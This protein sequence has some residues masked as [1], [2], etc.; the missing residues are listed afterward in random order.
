MIL[1]GITL[2]FTS[3]FAQV[4]LSTDVPASVVKAFEAK[5][6][7]ASELVWEE[8][9]GMWE[10]DFVLA[11]QAYEASFGANG[12][13]MKTQQE[14]SPEDVPA[15]ITAALE[16]EMPGFEIEDAEIV[17]TPAGKFYEVDVL[18]GGKNVDIVMDLDGKVIKKNMTKD[19][20]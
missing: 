5:Y 4:D 13:W 17:E 14:I 10:V 1:A 9:N 20:N 19:N 18:V 15:S 3:L 6:A 12:T 16:T 2:V 11:K 7:G 8:Q